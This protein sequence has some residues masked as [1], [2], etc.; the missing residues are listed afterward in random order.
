MSLDARPGRGALPDAVN[1]VLQCGSRE[2]VQRI[3]L[4]NS[5]VVRISSIHVVPVHLLRGLERLGF[6]R[7]E[8]GG[9]G[10]G[11]RTRSAA[12]EAD[13]RG[14]Q[15]DGH[16]GP[17]RTRGASAAVRRADAGGTPRNHSHTV[18]GSGRAPQDLSTGT[19]HRRSTAFR[20]ARA[21]PVLAQR[22]QTG[23]LSARPHSLNDPGGERGSLRSRASPERAQPGAMPRITR[24][25]RASTRAAESGRP[26]NAAY[27]VAARNW[28]ATA[29]GSA[30]AR[31]APSS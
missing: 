20:L 5:I 1:R 30:S 3:A 22:P 2:V 13:R 31:T 28:S 15:G 6:A 19:S 24:S 18:T 8:R 16:S 29:A 14:N 25:T 27:D 12:G 11:R 9:R 21:S 17:K 23:V 10:F 26:S 7:E 4:L